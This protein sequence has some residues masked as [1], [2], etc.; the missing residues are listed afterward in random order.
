MRKC[1]N[2]GVDLPDDASYCRMCGQ[3]L[4]PVVAKSETVNKAVTPPLPSG[5][6]GDKKESNTLSPDNNDSNKNKKNLIAAICIVGSIIVG[7]IIWLSIAISEVKADKE[8]EIEHLT[9]VRHQLLEELKERMIAQTLAREAE[10]KRID[11]ENELRQNVLDQMIAILKNTK[12]RVSKEKPGYDSEFLNEYISYIN[13][14]T[15][16]YNNDS[17]PE[18][19]IFL[20][21]G[22]SDYNDFEVFAMQPDGNV[23]R[24]AHD[25]II[26]Y[27][28]IKNGV[29]Y[30]TNWDSTETDWVWYISKFTISGSQYK[31]TIVQKGNYNYEDPP[32]MPKVKQYHISDYSH[33]KDSFKFIDL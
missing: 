1:K 8:K 2:C 11:Q 3:E 9:S 21:D 24:I 28:F 32:D 7:A 30:G 20:P 15:T 25:C 23:S 16:H 4:E 33:L 18:L 6:I 17:I 31:K 5:S 10:M 14:F 13:Y 22:F 26:G 19:W 27:F 12:S 29:I